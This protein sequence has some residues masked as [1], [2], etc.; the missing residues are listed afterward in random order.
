MLHELVITQ[1]MS[2]RINGKDIKVLR[3][4]SRIDNTQGWVIKSYANRWEY[5]D[6]YDSA[7]ARALQLMMEA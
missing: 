7:L 6:E 2:T 5:F 1:L 3:V 4:K